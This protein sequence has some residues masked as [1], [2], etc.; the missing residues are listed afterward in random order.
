VT[1]LADALRRAEN[2]IQVTEI[3]TIDYFVHQDTRKR[4]GKIRAPQL[5]KLLKKDEERGEHFHT[6][7]RDI[8]IEIKGK[9]MLRRQKPTLRALRRRQPIETPTK[10]RN[11]NKYSKYH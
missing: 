10:Y 5:D 1:S 8:L 11:K 7:P 3:C 2:F 9:L 4:V 6:N